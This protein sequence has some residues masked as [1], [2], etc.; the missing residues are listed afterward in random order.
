MVPNDHIATA[1]GV[2]EN[3]RKNSIDWIEKSF[4]PVDDSISKL[5][6]LIW[7]VLLGDSSIGPIAVFAFGGGEAA[8]KRKSDLSSSLSRDGTR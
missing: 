2:V 1:I 6:S 3:S 8:V 5:F 4:Q 7:N